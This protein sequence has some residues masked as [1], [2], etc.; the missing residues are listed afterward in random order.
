MYAQVVRR[1]WDYITKICYACIAY[2]SRASCFTRR[3]LFDFVS[4]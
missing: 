3:M 1:N 4:K 2:P